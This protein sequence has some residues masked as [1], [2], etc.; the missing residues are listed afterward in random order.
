MGLI[1]IV[2]AGLCLN[3]TCEV[4]EGIYLLHELF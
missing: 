3:A 4:E 2:L 1:E